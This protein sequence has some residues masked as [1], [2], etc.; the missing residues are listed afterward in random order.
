MSDGGDEGAV[1]HV[2][3]GG[4]DGDGS[5]VPDGGDEGAAV[6]VICGDDVA[7]GVHFDEG[8]GVGGTSLRSLLLWQSA[9]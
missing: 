6:P 3:D 2:I 8:V 1:V 7:E 9:T 5:G 4:G